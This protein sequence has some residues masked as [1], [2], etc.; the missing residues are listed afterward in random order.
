[1]LA[2][3]TATLRPPAMAAASAG[4]SSSQA[5]PAEPHLSPHGDFSSS[6]QAADA[7]A[8]WCDGGGREEADV[9]NLDSPWVSAA[10]A[11]SILEKAAMVA[12]LCPGAEDEVRANQERQQDEVRQHY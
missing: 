7:R 6:S 11:E 9:L 1:M 10:E 4:A 5:Q 8:A 3:H 12:G 2:T